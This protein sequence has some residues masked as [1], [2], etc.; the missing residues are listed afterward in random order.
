[1]IGIYQQ[2]LARRGLALSLLVSATLSR[3]VQA[4]NE[5]PLWL[6][7]S[8]GYGG[9]SFSC[10]SCTRHPWL[11]GVVSSLGFGAGFNPH[12]H[13]ALELRTWDQF[14]SRYHIP[15]LELISLLATYY[16]HVHGGPF[17]EGGLCISHYRFGNGIVDIIDPWPTDSTL[18]SGTG[19][20]FM[21]GAGWRLRSWFA[22][23]LT[24]GQANE[25]TLR[26]P[27]RAIVST[28]W[29]HRTLMLEVGGRWTLN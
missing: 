15:T 6:G 24:Y 22:P 7:I 25:G 8:L 9:A 26:T 28:S 2:T 19:W 12:L 1:M 17:V 29:R 10:D 13:A 21:L 16:P 18:Y 5:K 27:G 20:G 3:G 14:G 4:Q 23:R 11:N